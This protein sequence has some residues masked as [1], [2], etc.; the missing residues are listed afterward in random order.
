MTG[1][2]WLTLPSYCP[3]LMEVKAETESETTEGNSLLSH[4]L[5]GSC[6]AAFLKWFRITCPE[7][8]AA[9][10]GL[11]PLALISIQD[12]FA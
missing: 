4:F 1:C 11:G 2:I 7:D 9:Y 10:S 6:L 12:N 3:P 8:S 5:V